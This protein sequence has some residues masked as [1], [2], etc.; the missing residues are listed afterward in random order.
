MEEARRVL[1]RAYAAFNRRDVDGALECMRED[2]SWPKA[3][4]GG[5]VVGKEEVRA[6]WRR[7]WA[8]FDPMV[9]PVDFVERADGRVDVRVHQVV[10]RVEG[11][12]L[13]DGEVWH[14]YVLVDGLIERMEV[15]EGAEEAFEKGRA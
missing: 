13:F 8:E 3:S 1:E 14:R 9:T 11:E 10:K 5:S 2:V 15:G 7:Q 12:V 4:E 6:Y